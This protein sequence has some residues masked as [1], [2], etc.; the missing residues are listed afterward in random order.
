VFAPFFQPAS[1][2]FKLG[3]DAINLE[4]MLRAESLC[5]CKEAQHCKTVSMKSGCSAQ[6]FS[7][8]N[9]LA[10]GMLVL[11]TILHGI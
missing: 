9:R 2:R 5:V 1:E 3:G 8:R 10:L 11:I 6:K 7:K 4:E